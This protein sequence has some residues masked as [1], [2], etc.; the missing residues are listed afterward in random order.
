MQVKV[1]HMY[2]VGVPGAIPQDLNRAMYFY[3]LAADQVKPI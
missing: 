2:E 3:S 1:G